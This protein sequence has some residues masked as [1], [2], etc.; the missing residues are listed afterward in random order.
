ILPAAAHAIGIRE[1]EAAYEKR[2][3]LA[4][5][6]IVGFVGAIAKNQAV[7]DEFPFDRFDRAAEAWILRGQEP[8]LSDQQE[9]GVEGRSVV[10]LDESVAGRVVTSLQNLGVN[11][12][13]D[14][15]PFV[16][17][18]VGVELLYSFDCTIERHPCHHLRMDEV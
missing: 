18:T 1:P 10:V 6:A 15:T 12:I 9:G 14:R 13:A 7:F 16:D 11:L 4:G 8:D 5:E 17:R 2:A 3:F